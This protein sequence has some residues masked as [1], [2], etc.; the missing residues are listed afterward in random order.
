MVSFL[1]KD[2]TFTQ[3]DAVYCTTHSAV[4]VD[5]TGAEH[6]DVVPIEQQR[7][8]GA[9]RKTPCFNALDSFSHFTSLESVLATQKAADF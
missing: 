7:L 3:N 6:G 2:F 4:G 1:K 9:C 8:A 5:D